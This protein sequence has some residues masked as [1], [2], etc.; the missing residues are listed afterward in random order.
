MFAALTLSRLLAVAPAPAP[1]PALPP[2]IIR[3]I[4]TARR[5]TLHEMMPPIGYVTR[6]HD[7]AS[8]QASPLAQR[9]HVRTI[10]PCKKALQYRTPA[11]Q[12][13]LLLAQVI[14]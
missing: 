5:T 10:G 9:P 8:N 3:T 1:T 11:S 4:T 7:D 2:V 14:C 12:R 6:R 13:M